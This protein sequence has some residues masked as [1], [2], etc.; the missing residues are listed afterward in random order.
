MKKH[1]HSEPVGA[2]ALSCPAYARPHAEETFL[3][4]QTVLCDSMDGDFD[5]IVD[6]TFNV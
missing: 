6:D 1:I 5:D 4:T 2:G 3:N